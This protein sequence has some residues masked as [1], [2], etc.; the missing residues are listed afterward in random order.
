MVDSYADLQA[1]YCAVI[2]AEPFPADFD[3]TGNPVLI[4]QQRR[5]ISALDKF[6]CHV[7]V[8]FDPVRLRNENQGSLALFGKLPCGVYR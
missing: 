1:L 7:A 6:E 2:V 5:Q 8:A 3:R 4:L